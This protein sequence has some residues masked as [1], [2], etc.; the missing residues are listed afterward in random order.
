MLSFQELLNRIQDVE[1]RIQQGLGGFNAQRIMAPMARLSADDYLRSGQINPRQGA[2]LALIYPDQDRFYLCMM[3]RPQYQGV[4]SGQISFPGGKMELSDPDL[5]HTALREAHEEVNIQPEDII[6]TTTLTQVYIPPSNFLVSPF[7]AL[8]RHK[9]RFLPDALEVEAI[10]QLPL[11][12]LFDEKRIE[13]GNI[14]SSLGIIKNYPYFNFSVGQVWG[15]TAM[16]S[17]EIR[18]LL[19]S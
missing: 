16:I 15:A 4:H 13:S 8:G 1:T 2:V 12:E 10:L 6:Y 11:D 7:L 19:S 5:L 3:K 9:P 17:S 14:P 18:S